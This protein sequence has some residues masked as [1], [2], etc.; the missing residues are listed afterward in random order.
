MKMLVLGGTVFLGR[1]LV[2]AGLRQGH[3]VTTFTRGEHNPDAYPDVESLRGNRDGDLGALQGRTWDVVVDTSGYVPRVVGDSAR[4]LADAVDRYIFISTLSVYPDVSTPGID[5]DTP[6][7]IM[8]DPT[9]EEITG[10]TYG[11]LKA[12]CERAVDGA[13]PGRTLIIRP[14][15]IVGMYDPTDRFTYWPHRI[16]AGGEVLAPDHPVRS[17]QIIDGQDLAE[18]SVSMAQERATGVFNATGPRF[19]LT[20]GEIVDESKAQTESDAEI[21]WVPGEFLL[22]HQV[23]PWSDMPLWVPEGGEYA[24][25][26]NFDISRAVAHGL[27]FRPLANTIRDTLRWDRTRPPNYTLKAGLAPERER[28]VLSAWHADSKHHGRAAE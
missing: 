6:V 25:F 3:E 20:M 2:E 23:R 9:V 22:E 4:L 16:A 10:E 24:G 19:P 27:T 14:G 18:W 11:P 1:H 12:L 8:E 13:L 26:N 17:T 21:T 28:Q 15:L 5:E 7:A